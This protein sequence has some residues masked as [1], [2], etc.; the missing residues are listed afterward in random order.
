MTA[1]LCSIIIPCY[2]HAH[3]LPDALN[4]VLAQT[5]TDWEAIIVDDG[6]TDN[7]RAVAAQFTDPRIHYIYQE[8]RGQTAAL[9]RGLELVSG[10]Y[11]TTLDADDWL[12]PASLLERVT[13]LEA[14]PELGAVYCDGY[15]CGSSGE[16][17][18]RF[19]DNRSGNPTGDI[20][21]ALIISSV[22]GAGSPVMI[23]RAILHQHGLR[24]DESI[25]WCQDWD[26]YIRV[27]EWASFGYVDSPSVY[28][29][30]HESNMTLTMPEGRRLQSLIRTGRKVLDSARFTAVPLPQKRAFFYR[31]LV[32]DL[33]T[34]SKIRKR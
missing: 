33:K 18:K 13:C 14:H 7:T 12:T 27:S 26:F 9:N 5:Y 34:E 28:Y 16:I 2:N 20:Y 32:H 21:D 23:R 24:Y 11:V 15:Y 19:S 31:F 6:S 1:P 22:F 29:R 4:S 17:L 30:L 3:Y 25:V 8:N 10:D